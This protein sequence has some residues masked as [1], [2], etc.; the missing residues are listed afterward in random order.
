MIST[1]TILIA[2]GCGFVLSFFIGLFSRNPFL[3]V[4]LK[5]LLTALVFA[6]LSEAVFILYKKFLSDDV[7]DSDD[8]LASTADDKNEKSGFVGGSAVD[9]SVEGEDLNEDDSSPQFKI[10]SAKKTFS[11]NNS[12]GVKSE[13]KSSESEKN[14]LRQNQNADFGISSDSTADSESETQNETEN[15]K[16]ASEN[17]AK[18]EVTS[19]AQATSSFVPLDPGKMEHISSANV[20]VAAE[21][22]SSTEE[23][24]DVLPDIADF[25]SGKKSDDVGDAPVRT[26]DFVSGE[27]SFSGTS[28]F[29]GK[30]FSGGEY[31]PNQD[32][33]TMAKAIKTLLSKD[34]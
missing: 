18:N 15:V 14:D 3:S 12:F 6:G 4:V 25:S 23:E 28:L 7:S 19:S 24:L 31:T 11:V 16:R 34:N 22:K 33:E 9:I 30:S 10:D 1:K 20:S 2:A 8:S 32:A 29:S 21:K 13:T 17:N 26:S 27:N 5:A